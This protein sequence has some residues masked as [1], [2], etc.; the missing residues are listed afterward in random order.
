MDT[1]KL[2]RFEIIDHTPCQYCGGRG[3]IRLEQCTNCEGRGCPGRKVVVW[4]DS[5][6]IDVEVQDDGRTLKVLIHER[7]EETV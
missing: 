1:S 3:T 4:D 6:Q 2:N 5:K 7:Y